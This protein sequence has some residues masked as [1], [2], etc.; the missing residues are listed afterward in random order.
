MM[1]VGEPQAP[2]VEDALPPGDERQLDG[3]GNHSASTLTDKYIRAAAEGRLTVDRARCYD[4]LCGLTSGAPPPADICQRKV[5][6]TSVM[7]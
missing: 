4:A 5:C 2:A 1:A 7:L 6:A 3:N